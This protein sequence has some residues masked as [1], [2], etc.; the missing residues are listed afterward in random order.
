MHRWGS[1]YFSVFYFFFSF[2][3]GFRVA[4]KKNSAGHLMEFGEGAFFA[5][6]LKTC[7]FYLSFS[8]P[9]MGDFPLLLDYEPMT[10]FGI[11]GRKKVYKFTSF[12]NIYQP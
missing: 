3:F 7:V 5:N 2:P 11:P 4:E 8:H 12:L 9:Y 1:T 10:R 6:I